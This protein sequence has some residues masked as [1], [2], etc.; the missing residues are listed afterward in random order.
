MNFKKSA[1]VN[2]LEFLAY[3]ESFVQKKYSVFF[4]HHYHF[5]RIAHVVRKYILKFTIAHNYM[6]TKTK[7]S[8]TPIKSIADDKVCCLSNDHSFIIK[9]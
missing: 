2:K 1:T 6:A 8:I 4:L 9:K 5:R 7:A 3:I